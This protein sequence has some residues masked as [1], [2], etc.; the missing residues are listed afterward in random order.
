MIN[1]SPP[2]VSKDI[3]PYN[4]AAQYNATNTLHFK[5]FIIKTKPLNAE[6]LSTNW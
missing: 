6:I 1:F 4:V 5:G 3:V 2:K